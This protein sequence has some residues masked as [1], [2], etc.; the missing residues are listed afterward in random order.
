MNKNA[1]F[2]LKYR[3]EKKELGTALGWSKHT[4]DKEPGNEDYK[5][6]YDALQTRL[7]GK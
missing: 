5:K 1:N 4:V 3:E 2:I 6:T 7:N